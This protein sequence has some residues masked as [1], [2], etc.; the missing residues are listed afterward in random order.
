M[1]QLAKKW[2]GAKLAQI[3]LNIQEDQKTVKIALQ[4]LVRISRN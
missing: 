1:T 2:R 4:I 3:A